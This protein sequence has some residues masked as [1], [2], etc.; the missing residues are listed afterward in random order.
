MAVIL[1]NSLKTQQE[2]TAYFA[3]P[4]VWSLASVQNITDVISS[5]NTL[6]TFT[7]LAT[8]GVVYCT[9]TD[10]EVNRMK[11]GAPDLSERLRNISSELRAI[12]LELRSE[13]ITPDKVLL[14]E[15]RQVLDDVRLTAWT[16]NELMNAHE[17]PENLLSFIASE[18]MRRLSCMIKDLCSDMDKEVFTWQSSGVQNLSDAVL[19]LQSRITKLI[20]RHRTQRQQLGH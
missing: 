20:A 11:D 9:S 7:F 2:E 14:Q 8:G 17:S 1:Q 4:G 10:T 12:D 5:V 13:S 3:A 18:R 15:F 6:R 16:V 19:V